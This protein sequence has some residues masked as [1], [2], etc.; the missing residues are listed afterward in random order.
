[1]ITIDDA[2]KKMATFLDERGP[3][4]EGGLILLDEFTIT[5]PYGWVF[6]YTS[7]LWFETRDIA[8]GIAGNGPVVVLADSGAVVALGTAR[9]AEDEIAAFEHARG[10][11]SC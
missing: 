10:L 4:I 8:Y 2:K 1:M 6:S 9:S 3:K 5:K 7:R 11:E